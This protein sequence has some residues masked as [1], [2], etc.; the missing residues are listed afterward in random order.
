MERLAGGVAA[1]VVA[2]MTGYAYASIAGFWLASLRV[3]DHSLPPSGWLSAIGIASAVGYVGGWSIG[4]AGFVFGWLAAFPL[5][6]VLCVVWRQWY[7][8]PPLNHP[9]MM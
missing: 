8:G 4:L 6:Y 7:L 1:V 5:G 2:I 3:R 9:D